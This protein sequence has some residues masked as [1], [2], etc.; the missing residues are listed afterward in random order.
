MTIIKCRL[1]LAN[2]FSSFA[3]SDLRLPLR[4]TGGLYN[5]SNDDVGSDVCCQVRLAPNRNN[6]TV[7]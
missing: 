7:K 2:F 3:E 4:G 5:G 6:F 1:C